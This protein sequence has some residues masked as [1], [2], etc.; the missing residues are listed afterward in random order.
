MEPEEYIVAVRRSQNHPGLLEI[1][2]RIPEKD[3][4]GNLVP[5][6]YRKIGQVKTVYDPAYYSDEQMAEWG[7]EA[8]REA[9]KNGRITSKRFQGQA[10]NGMWFQGFYD[11]ET[12][13]ITNY[14]P[15]ILE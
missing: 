15:I 3:A 14:Y 2:Y 5:G 4:K 12:S 7:R 8:M 10:S 1:E 6:S 11:E 9:K 13:R